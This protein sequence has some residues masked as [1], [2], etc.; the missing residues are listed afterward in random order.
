MSQLYG[1]QGKD[2]RVFGPDAVRAEIAAVVRDVASVLEVAADDAEAML[3]SCSW[4]KQRLLERFTE[5][6]EQVR[7]GAGLAKA[8]S[9]GAGAAEVDGPEAD[10]PVCFASVPASEM[11]SLACGHGACRECWGE[12]LSGQLR[13]RAAEA[14][15]AVCMESDCS[16]IVPHAFVR[17][18]GLAAARGSDPMALLTSWDR[19]L[20]RHFVEHSRRLR[21]CPGSGCD[22]AFQAVSAGR[23][24]ECESCGSAFCL[25]CGRGAHRPVSCSM[26]SSWL[27]KCE[28]ESETANWII[29]NT[30]RCPKCGVRIEKN[31]GCM[32]MKCGVCKHEFCWVCTGDWAMHGQKTGGYYACNRYTGQKTQGRGVPGSRPGK[33]G[34]GASALDKDAEENLAKAELDRYLFYYQRYSGHMRAGTFA[35][36]QRERA[37]QRMAEVAAEGLAWVEV[38]FLEQ[39]TEVLLACRRVLQFTYVMAYFMADGREKSLFEHLQELLEGSTEELS[40]LLERPLEEMD[41][42]QV[43]N[44]TRVT[45]KFLSQLLEGVDEG[46]VDG[47]SGAGAA[48]SAASSAAAEEAA[49]AKPGGAKSTSPSGKRKPTDRARQRLRAA[50]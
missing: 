7:A 14:V 29:V 45:A 33:K 26:L 8:G 34:A 40:E 41:R 12:Y 27:E 42:R 35:A 37:Q 5:R 28:D 17:H 6:P 32:H 3:L 36:G 1:E 24:V 9:R 30:K 44:F 16:C 10:C 48:S 47:A 22:K 11:A 4:D 13:S 25:G 46:L 21:W 50:R 15:E 19:S 31:Q 20:C 39:G 43:V 18:V 49:A 2:Y 23:D 38:D